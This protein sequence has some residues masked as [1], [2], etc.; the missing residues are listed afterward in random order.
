MPLSAHE[1]WYESIQALSDSPEQ[2]DHHVA[3]DAY[4][5]PFW[6][7]EHD[8]SLD[9][10]SLN[11]PTDESIMEAMNVTELPWTDDHHRSSFCPD[12]QYM[13]DRL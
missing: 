1:K 4:P 3:A 6:L 11:L 7:P 10:L 8:R 13:E 2:H 9:Y 12:I 5:L